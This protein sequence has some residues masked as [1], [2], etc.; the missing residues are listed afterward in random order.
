MDYQTTVKSSSKGPFSLDNNDALLFFVVR[1]EKKKWVAWLPMIL[2][3]LDDKKKTRRHWLKLIPLLTSP[4]LFL[5]TIL[6]TL[7]A[8]VCV[9]VCVL[10]VLLK[11]L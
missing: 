8:S 1:N 6:C 11:R 10:K 7:S 2:F 4:G 5:D 3:T 9:C